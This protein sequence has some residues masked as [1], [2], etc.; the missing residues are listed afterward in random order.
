VSLPTAT[1]IVGLVTALAPGLVILGIRQWFVAAPPPK[2]EERAFN[3]VAASIVY[4]AIFGP[5]AVMAGKV[6]QPW[7]VHALEYLVVPAIVGVALGAAALRDVSD[8]LW[9]VVGLQPV[10]HAPTAWDYAFTRLKVAPYVLVTL[11]DGS[12]VAG[13]YGK[14]S[15]AASSPDERDLLICEMFDSDH[16][17]WAQ[18]S[19]PRSI[20]LCG[21]DIRFV[22]FF[23]E[24]TDAER[25]PAA[26]ARPTPEGVSSAQTG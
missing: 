13:R 9:G 1:E 16:R 23:Q 15:F 24:L 8:R 26:E 11:S 25:P 20:L 4:Y 7:L 6:W 14:G 10:H 3:Y 22:E 17:P 12:Q 5:L 2:L 21:R 19:P 18:I